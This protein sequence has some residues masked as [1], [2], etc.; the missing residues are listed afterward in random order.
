MVPR[1]LKVS[2]ICEISR[3]VSIGRLTLALSDL[4]FPFKYFVTGGITLQ[5]LSQCILLKCNN[6]K[7]RTDLYV[8]G[9]LPNSRAA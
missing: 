9:Y 2:A 4:N 6:V 7:K 5:P 8:A 3:K 1:N